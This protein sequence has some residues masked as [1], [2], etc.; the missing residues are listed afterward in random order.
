M[1]RGHFVSTYLGNTD[2]LGLDQ[3]CSDLET[4]ATTKP[5]LKTIFFWFGLVIA[6]AFVGQYCHHKKLETLSHWFYFN[7]TLFGPLTSE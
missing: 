4:T 5:T 6:F 3:P 7:N 2:L 1:F